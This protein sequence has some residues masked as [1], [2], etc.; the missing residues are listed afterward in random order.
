MTHNA[1][2]QSNLRLYLQSESLQ[3]GCI[4]DTVVYS[5][6]SRHQKTNK[7]TIWGEDNKIQVTLISLRRLIE[8]ETVPKQGHLLK[9]DQC[10]VTR[11]N[12][13]FRKLLVFCP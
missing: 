11:N 13:Q 2:S 4:L 6:A 1:H 10:Y 5:G 3:Q 12:T 8:R 7:S 9:P